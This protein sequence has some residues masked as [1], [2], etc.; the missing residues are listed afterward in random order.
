ME[1][2]IV[3]LQERYEQVCSVLNRHSNKLY[4]CPYLQDKNRL[5]L[6]IDAAGRESQTLRKYIQYCLMTNQ[7]FP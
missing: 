2:D 5:L 3:G 1:Q 7:T 6:S 4:L